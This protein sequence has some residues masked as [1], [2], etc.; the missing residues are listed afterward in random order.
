M[1]KYGIMAAVFA[2]GLLFIGIGSGIAFAEFSSFTYGGK[3]TFGNGQMEVRRF[4]EE[5]TPDMAFRL[6]RYRNIDVVEDENLPADKLIFEIE[7]NPEFVEPRIEKYTE[8]IEIFDEEETA[9]EETVG[10]DAAGGDMAESDVS[11]DGL[12]EEDR[13]REKMKNTEEVFHIWEN[14]K[15]EMELMWGVKDEV[16]RSVKERKIYDYDVEYF[17]KMTV[18]MSPQAKEYLK[19]R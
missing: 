5:R 16:L 19:Y 10:E 12:T 3:S 2:A 7:Y 8:E 9:V 14:S 18:Y 15:N 4:E 6:D 17:G 1:K 13:I 11:G